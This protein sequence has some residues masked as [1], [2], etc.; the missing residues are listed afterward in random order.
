M[1]RKRNEKVVAA[2]Y[3]LR[4]MIEMCKRVIGKRLESCAVFLHK[5]FTA[6]F[7][8]CRCDQLFPCEI[9]ENIKGKKCEWLVKVG[10]V[11]FFSHVVICLASYKP[12]VV[13]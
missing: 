12:P 3:D 8:H 9:F 6:C 10:L 2:D 4:L 11:V 13:K 7:W 1:A 5:T